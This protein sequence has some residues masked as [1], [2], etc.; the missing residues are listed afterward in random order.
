MDMSLIE[1]GSLF[2]G[3]GGFDYGLQQAGMRIVWQCEKD[4][5]CQRLLR[6]HWPDI[7]LHEDITKDNDYEPVDL[8]CGG[9]PCQSR[10]RAKGTWRSKHPDLS[11]YFL[12]V[13]GRLQ[14]RWVVREN[15]PAPD[16]VAFVTA[17][18]VLGY[19]VVIVSANS[20]LLTAQNRERDFNVQEVPASV[21]CQ[22]E[23]SKVL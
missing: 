21:T 1:V 4:K 10:S 9:D 17:L 11:G 7:T 2:T 20:A 14:P 18:E 5:L 12:A 13:V 15:V 19:R 22:Q 3:C 8:V 16:V 23:Q 6:K